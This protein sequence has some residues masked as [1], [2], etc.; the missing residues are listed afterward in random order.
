M[1][2]EETS[3]GSRTTKPRTAGS[4]GYPAPPIP[5]TEPTHTQAP[6]TSG[7]ERHQVRGYG[8]TRALINVHSWASRP[9]RRSRSVGALDIAGS[10]AG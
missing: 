7:I 2:A 4:A 10:S 1:K 8:T 3:S 9:G 5:Q 6:S